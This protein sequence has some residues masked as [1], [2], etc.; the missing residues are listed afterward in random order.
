MRVNPNTFA[1]AAFF[2]GVIFAASMINGTTALSVASFLATVVAGG[3]YML[4]AFNHQTESDKALEKFL[5]DIRRFLDR[6]AKKPSW[7]EEKN[8]EHQENDHRE[9][10]D[11]RTVTS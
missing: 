6:Q 3:K 1:S 5:G 8:E 10:G 9:Q 2:S 4:I 7:E 11:V